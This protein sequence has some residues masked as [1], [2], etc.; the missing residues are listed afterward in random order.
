MSNTL[1]SSEDFGLK[2]YER[3]PLAYREMDEHYN[4]ALRRYLQALS[5]G[6]FKYSIE[7]INGL[8][9]LVDPD[10][11]S[12][13]VLP[14]LYSQYGLELFNGIPEKYLRYFLPFLGLAYSKKGSLGVIPFITTSLSG[15]RTSTD[16]V[17]DTY[18]N[19][20]MD[21]TLEMDYQVAGN[22]FFPKSEQFKRI[23]ENFL[24]FY[25]NCNIIY[26]YILYDDASLSG[27]E[28]SFSDRLSVSNEEQDSI[29]NIEYIEDKIIEVVPNDTIELL[30]IK[31]NNQY[32]WILNNTESLLNS[33]TLVNLDVV[34]KITENGNV[35]VGIPTYLNYIM[36]NQGS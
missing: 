14:F 10:V 21:V 6:G 16:I 19:P 7:E 32:C 15:I 23:L 29:V 25:V 1:L 20:E 12:A 35:K 8:L 2:I 13:D 9:D 34:D 18:G 22:D 36:L 28:D 5:D 3:F 33:C 11:V 17:L 24:P 4:L 26:S 27:V 31:N 30:G